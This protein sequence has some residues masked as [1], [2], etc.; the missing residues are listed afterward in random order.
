MYVEDRVSKTALMPQIFGAIE[1][2]LQCIFLK[3]EKSKPARV[4]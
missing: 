2:K 4:M 3:L 1:L